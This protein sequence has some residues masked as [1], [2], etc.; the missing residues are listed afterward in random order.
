MSWFR[1]EDSRI[2]DGEAQWP[3]SCL[4]GACIIPGCMQGCCLTACHD[5]A[6]FSDRHSL[7]GLE[8]FL[9]R[10]SQILGGCF[11]KCSLEPGK[12]SV[13]LLLGLPTKPVEGK[14]HPLDRASPS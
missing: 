5:S 13:S 4:A 1:A 8:G 9:T 2:S 14:L 11:L 6:V 3:L 10:L 7:C 12:G